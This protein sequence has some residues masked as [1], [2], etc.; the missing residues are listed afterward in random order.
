M[1]ITVKNYFQKGSARK[2]RPILAVIRRKN[3]NRV[4]ESL[5]FMNKNGANE[6]YKM[7]LNGVS[8]AEENNI[9]KDKLIIKKIQ[10]DK[11]KELK[12]H[13]FESKGRVARIQKHQHHISMILSDESERILKNAAP[14]TITEENNIS[15]KPKKDK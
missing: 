6:L 8:V 4:L 10:C 5:K 2:I 1:E 3:V 7:I 14:K 13:R 9:D 11:A 15:S 12:R